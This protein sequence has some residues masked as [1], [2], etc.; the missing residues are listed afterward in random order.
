M[1]SWPKPLR[2]GVAYRRRCV[3]ESCEWEDSRY[4]SEPKPT[5]NVLIFGMVGSPVDAVITVV[6]SLIGVWLRC[7]DWSAFCEQMQIIHSARFQISE[8]ED[9]FTLAI[10]PVCLLAGR[11]APRG[12][13]LGQSWS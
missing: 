13:V 2:V 3:S 7:K 1:K 4:A 9:S 12:A 11:P 8:L 6:F 10:Q 5:L